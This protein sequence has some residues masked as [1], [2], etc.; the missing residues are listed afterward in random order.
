MVTDAR[1]RLANSVNRAQQTSATAYSSP[2]SHADF[3]G[4]QTETPPNASGL[5]NASVNCAAPSHATYVFFHKDTTAGSLA[6][7]LWHAG[8]TE[9]QEPR[10]QVRTIFEGG[11]D[12]LK[13]PPTVQDD[14]P[15]GGQLGD[16]L[17][18]TTDAGDPV[19]EHFYSRRWGDGVVYRVTDRTAQIRLRFTDIQ[20]REANDP[21]PE[22]LFFSTPSQCI[23]VTDGGIIDVPDAPT[24]IIRNE[25]PTRFDNR[26]LAVLA[27]GTAGGLGAIA[28][29]KRMGTL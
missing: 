5:L 19:T 6:L 29:A 17:Y 18:E 12:S 10:S 24:V 22:M 28:V 13:T 26:L 14:P 16:D 9:Q 1:R 23:N 15:G 25:L 3:Y 21:N 4:Y 8:L 11:T 20:A 7:G 27:A 2:E